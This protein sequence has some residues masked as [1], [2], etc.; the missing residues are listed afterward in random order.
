M[1]AYRIWN[2]MAQDPSLSSASGVRMKKSAFFFPYRL[3]DNE[4]Q[5][6]KMLEIERSG[7]HGFKHSSSLIEH[8]GVNPHYGCVDAYELSAPIIDT[9]QAMMWLM[10]LVKAKGARF[11]TGTVVGDIFDQERELRQRFEADVI[12]NAT[13]LAGVTTAGDTSCYAIRGALLRVRNDGTDFAKLDAALSVSAAAGFETHTSNEIVFLVPRN[14]NVLLV[15]GISEPHQWALDHTVRSPIIQLMKARCEAFLPRLKHSQ[16][17]VEYPLAQGL[18]PFRKSNVRVE[19]ETRKHGWSSG[20]GTTQ[21]DDMGISSRVIHTYGH[22]GSGW[23]LSFGCAEDVS[24]LVVEI[25]G[26][27]R[28]AKADENVR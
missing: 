5:Y 2:N 27:W 15:G 11:V 4:E 25:L 20:T 14:D 22:G 3:G 10:S 8:Y 13:G 6:A 24:K 23:S 16:L 12:V 19:R 26:R 18:R 9:D 7:V 28:C 17:D 21:D 1:T